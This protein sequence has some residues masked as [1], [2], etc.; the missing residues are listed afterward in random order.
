MKY[1]SP[2]SQGFTLVEL[3]ITIAIIATLA[4][5]VVPTVSS[6]RQMGQRAQTM[7]NLHSI[8]V[9]LATYI[10]E[11]DGTLPGPSSVAVF[12]IYLTGNHS[13]GATPCGFQQYLGPYLNQAPAPWMPATSDYVHLPSMDCPALSI[14]ARR[15]NGVAQFVK[16]DYGPSSPDNRFGDTASNMAD[17]TAKTN[18]PKKLVALTDTGRRSA[19]ITTADKQSWQSTSNTLLPAT[20]I[21]GGKRLYL[22]LDGSVEGPSDKGATVWAR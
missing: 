10:G 21:F 1:S 4:A 6:A 17:A 14:A 8:G 12:N 22:F 11:N 20:G 3:L 5:L 16:L 18:R 13:P 9:A 19:I 15:T 7:A 2:R